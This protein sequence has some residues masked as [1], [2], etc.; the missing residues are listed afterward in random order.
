MS[1]V[2][3]S[4]DE[5]LTDQ[6]YYATLGQEEKRRARRMNE[7]QIEYFLTVAQ[8]G[9]FAKAEK[10]LYVSRQAIMKQIDRLEEEI[11]VQLFQRDHTGL[12]LTAAGETLKEGM[13]PLMEQMQTLLENCRRTSCQE[14]PLC[15]EIPKHPYSLLDLA[16]QRFSKQY[17]Y[18][19]LNIV[20]EHSQGRVQRLL[21]GKIDLAEIP[22]RAEVE[23]EG[24]QYIDLIT[25]PFYC[26]VMQNHPIA[27]CETVSATDLQKWEVYVNSLSGRHELIEAL[28]R[29]CP[30]LEIRE[31]VGE[32]MEIVQNVCY[33]NG[34]YITPANF[35]KH[36][37]YLKA[38]P[39]S[40]G[41]YQ[42]IGLICRKEHNRAVENFIQIVQE[43]M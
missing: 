2:G 33:N 34:I 20:R 43:C 5:K 10:K 16:M 4:L 32:E 17:P 28:Y 39:L 42:R 14:Q 25:A 21:N 37:E 13:L 18:I 29:E 7:K 19:R 31:F 35:A 8:Y 12:S 22:H 36:M 23:A 15:I 41:V 11:G 40:C 6:R 38:I 1:T 26:L 9:S 3:Y 27:I 30:Q 24:V